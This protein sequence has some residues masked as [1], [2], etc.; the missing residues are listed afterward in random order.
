MSGNNGHGKNG[1]RFA[2]LDLQPVQA[3]PATAA[4]GAQNRPKTDAAMNAENH[5][6]KLERWID[7]LLALTAETVNAYPP[8]NAAAPLALNEDERRDVFGVMLDALR[9]LGVSWPIVVDKQKRACYVV[10]NFTRRGH[11]DTFHY[12]PMDG[13]A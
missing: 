6:Q 2:K 7:G 12:W 13:D 4:D 3:M 5:E 10:L 1:A 8:E 11:D 9:L